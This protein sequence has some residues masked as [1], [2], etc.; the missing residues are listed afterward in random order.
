MSQPKGTENEVKTFDVLNCDFCANCNHATLECMVDDKEIEPDNATDCPHFVPIAFWDNIVD[1]RWITV[2]YEKFHEIGMVF[3][4]SDHS[5]LIDYLTELNQLTNQNYRLPTYYE[6]FTFFK[7]IIYKATENDEI[8]KRIFC[9]RCIIPY[10]NFNQI[11]C[12]V[13][14][15]NNYKT[16]TAIECHN[17]EYD[18]TYAIAFLAKFIQDKD[19]TKEDL[20]DDF[21]NYLNDQPEVCNQPEEYEFYFELT[22]VDQSNSSFFRKKAFHS[23][24]EQFFVLQEKEIPLIIE[25]GIERFR[26]AKI[27]LDYKE[28]HIKIQELFEIAKQHHFNIK[29]KILTNKSKGYN[30]YFS[31]N[32]RDGYQVT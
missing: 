26:L 1:T 30:L 11:C 23:I 19:I 13:D 15:N 5:E 14:T 27:G 16:D 10:T 29:R 21:L 22:K 28:L 2:F 24:I 17:Y 20:H 25:D 3:L 4:D 7:E 8:R 12:R 9:K 31:I 18:D 32:D 6:F